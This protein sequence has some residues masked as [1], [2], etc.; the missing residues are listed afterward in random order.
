MDIRIDPSPLS[1]EIP[2]VSSKSDAH[3]LLICAALCAD[4]DTLVHIPQISQDIEATAGVLRA[5]GISIERTADGYLVHPTTSPAIS[6]VCDCGESGSTLRFLLPVISALCGCGSFEGQGRLPDRPI[7]ELVEAMREHG[8]SFSADRLPFSIT[9][10]LS[11]GDY[12]ISGNVSS[13]YI[14][15]LLMALPVVGGGRVILTTHLE[16]SRYVDMTVSTMAKFG[17]HVR[18]IPQ[19]WLVPEGSRYVS[20]GEASAQG[21][22]SNAAFFLTAGAISG[23]VT[24]LGLDTA[25]P[26][27]DKA[28][29]DILRRFGA[30]VSVADGRVSVMPGDLHGLDIELSEIPDLLP[31][32][33]VAAAYAEGETVFRGGARLRI[34]ESDRLS[35]VAAMLS[36]LGGDVT[37]LPEGLIVRGRPLTGGTVD[38][39]GD[40]R[41]VMA[42]STAAACCQGSSIIIGAQAVSKSYPGF[43]EDFRKLGGRAYV[44]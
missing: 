8:V 13:Q 11:S 26:Q 3:R 43:F 1:G 10:R 16:S 36:A 18:R 25:S 24:L 35:A 2:A 27:G 29:V 5:A 40:H 33:A 20:P 9:G 15:G 34:K 31:I 14:S 4:A 44:L 30:Q 12:M 37:E 42:A 38:G 17:V 6:P 39:F 23:G 41:I 19:G 21:D 28:I 7:G 32:L 22:W